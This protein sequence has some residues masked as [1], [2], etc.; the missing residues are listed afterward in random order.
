MLKAK[1]F[2]EEI[3]RGK[4]DFLGIFSGLSRTDLQKLKN[5][6]A[7]PQCPQKDMNFFSAKYL[8]SKKNWNFSLFAS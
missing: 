2:L 7:S 4:N 5:W 1:V 6:Q 3:L 8:H